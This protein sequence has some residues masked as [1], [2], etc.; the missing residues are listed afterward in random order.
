MAKKAKEDVAVPEREI[1]KRYWQ[2]S[3]VDSLTKWVKGIERTSTEKAKDKVQRVIYNSL[4]KL[5]KEG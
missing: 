3:S 1:I 4:P 5:R 2:G